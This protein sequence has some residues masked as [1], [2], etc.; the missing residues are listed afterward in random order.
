MLML[1][2]LPK[3]L[4]SIFHIDMCYGMYIGA[5]ILSIDIFVMGLLVS[6]DNNG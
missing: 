2:V 4:T 6:A 3:L 1:V 5:A